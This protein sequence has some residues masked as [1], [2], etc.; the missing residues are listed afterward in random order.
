MQNMHHKLIF[1]EEIYI[2]IILKLELELI[3]KRYKSLFVKYCGKISSG[4]NFY[5]TLLEYFTRLKI[6]IFMIKMPS[7]M[8]W[9]IKMCLY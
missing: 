9:A 6:K 2:K 3:T 8:P 1:N 4:I 5:L 7:A